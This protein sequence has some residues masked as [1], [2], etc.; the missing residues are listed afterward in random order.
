M[1]T[2]AALLVVG[3]S[4][5]SAARTLGIG[6]RTLFR[7]LTQASFRHEIDR[8]IAELSRGLPVASRAPRPVHARVQSQ[9][10]DAIDPEKLRADMDFLNAIA[11]R[12]LGANWRGSARNGTLQ[13]EM[14]KTNPPQG[15]DRIKTG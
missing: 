6:K 15:G 4:V 8:R 2:A 7:W 1:R 10:D 3:H 13:S 5:A 14:C 9:A 11:A 12:A